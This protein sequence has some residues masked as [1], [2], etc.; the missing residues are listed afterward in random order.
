MGPTREECCSRAKSLGIEKQEERLSPRNDS[1]QLPMLNYQWKTV[2][3]LNP[4]PFPQSR[5]TFIGSRCIARFPRNITANGRLSFYNRT[6]M[7]V[8]AIQDKGA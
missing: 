8:E 3:V 6:V 4:T 5:L 1:D 7:P 2:Q